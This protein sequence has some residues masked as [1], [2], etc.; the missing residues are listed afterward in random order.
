MKRARQK[1]L[2][3]KNQNRQ[4][5]EVI[6]FAIKEENYFPSRVAPCEHWRSFKPES[7]VF[8]SFFLR[9]ASLRAFSFSKS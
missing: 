3:A 6:K 1:K 9:E 4:Y 7:V 5:F 8:S 2:R